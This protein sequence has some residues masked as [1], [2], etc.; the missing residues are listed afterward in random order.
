MKKQITSL[1]TS[2]FAPARHL[3]ATGEVVNSYMSLRY[4]NASLAS[5]NHARRAAGEGAKFVGVSLADCVSRKAVVFHFEVR[6]EVSK[7]FAS[8]QSAQRYAKAA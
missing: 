1:K 6:V 2:D 4:Q 5:R 3:V 7:E 8:L